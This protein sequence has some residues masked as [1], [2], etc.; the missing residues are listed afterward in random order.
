MSPS[1]N[2][3]RDRSVLSNLSPPAVPFLGIFLQDAL[4][5]A[6][7]A[8]AIIDGRINFSKYDELSS[9]VTSLLRFQTS[10]YTPVFGS[11]VGKKEWHNAVA[12]LSHLYVMGDKDLFRI[13][14]QIEPRTS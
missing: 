9:I 7:C 14:R 11:K 10:D 4:H 2:Y 3:G 5:H 12:L 8:A 13:S 6:D 1:H